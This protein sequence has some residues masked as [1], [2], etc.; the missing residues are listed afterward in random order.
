[1]RRLLSPPSSFSPRCGTRAASRCP[2]GSLRVVLAAGGR[3]SP[4]LLG[5][6]L[7][8]DAGVAAQVLG[9]GPGERL[10]A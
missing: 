8:G 6:V 7:L 10:L 9:A 2:P 3:R 4:G 1:M 5:L